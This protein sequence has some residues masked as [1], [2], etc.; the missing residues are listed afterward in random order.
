MSGEDM[1]LKY[2]TII[3]VP[4]ERAKFRKWRVSNRQIAVALGVTLALTGAAISVSWL[5]FATSVNLD[6]VEHLRQENEALRTV[7]ESFESSIR[8]LQQ[9]LAEYEDRTKEL[10]IMAGLEGVPSKEGRAGLAGSG[11]GGAEDDA[12]PGD[13]YSLALLEA[14]AR[15]L[16]RRLDKV[17]VNIEEQLRHVASM[18]AIMPARGIFTSGY[19]YRL[20]PITGRRAFHNG[21]D[22]SA[23]PGK[24]VYATADGVVTRAGRNGSLGRAV[25]LAHGFGLSTRYGHLSEITV[26]PGQR[27][28]RGDLLGYVGNSGRTTGYHVHYEVREDSRPKNPMEYIL[29]RPSRSR[30]G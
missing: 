15:D 20:D 5:Y 24:S 12:Y 23:P 4:H 6:E 16:D 14:R 30:R 19:G 2:H 21:V 27:V 26:E 13:E 7:N 1:G 29:D 8:D 11:A 10:A 25:Y 28:K 18:P 9:N 17:S 3:V 22:I